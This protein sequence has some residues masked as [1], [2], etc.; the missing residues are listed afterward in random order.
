MA[1]M[2]KSPIP[3]THRTVLAIAVPVVLSNLTTPLL[4]LADTAVM[5]QLGGPQYIG[6]VAVGGLIF[7]FMFWAFGF[8]R[9]GTTGFTA[10]AYGADDGDEVRAA[11][12]RAL[13]LAGV[14]GIALIVLQWPFEQI[15][16]W[17]IDGS[18][19]VEALA[20]DYYAIRIWSAPA[21]LTNF[22][23]LGWFIGLQRA[24]TALVLQLI[25]NG[26]NI[27]LDVFFVI[28]LGWGVA[29][30]A[31]GTMI[32]E[33]TAAGCGLALAAMSLRG[34]AGG[35]S[36]TALLDWPRLAR[37]IIVNRDI[38]AR[39]LLLMFAFAFFVAQSAVAGNVA[40]AA[41]AVLMQFVFF[42]A[43]F[44]D[45]F[46]FAAEALV[47]QALGA[48]TRRAFDQAIKL[49]SLWS[50]GFAVLLSLGFGIL[51]PW[52]IDF[53]TIDLAVRAA[54]RDYLWWAAILPV[55]SFACYQ[56]DGVFIGATRTADMRD[57]AVLS[58]AVFL[59][60]WWALLP[61]GNH[62]LW[63]AL[64]IFNAVRAI[65]LG[66]YYPALARSVSSPL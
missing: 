1:D 2:N 47:G 25:L 6:A 18:A 61:F 52:F 44:L 22:A 57:A 43:F 11:L 49:S 9:M 45:G 42:A 30:V 39:T 28:G 46:A 21:A 55:V 38:M 63:A 66:R 53:L 36:R 33:V 34:I 14:A 64:M 5:G 62:G 54:A 26:V 16:F 15:A 29:G 12:G 13:V 40:L 3:V 23:L 8:L 35:W 4:G 7:N 51:G 65:F 59:I 37:T 50:G 19:D 32:A 48:K 60:V 41:N 24:R 17:L 56:L 27:G 10:Q 31:L 58:L 20:G